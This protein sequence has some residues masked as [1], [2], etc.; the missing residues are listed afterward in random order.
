MSATVIPFARKETAPASDNLHPWASGSAFCL[1]CKH[2]WTA[3]AQTGEQEIECPCCLRWTG[4]WRF[5]FQPTDGQL[6]RVC[7]CSNKLFYL[8]PEGHLCGSCGTYQSY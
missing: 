1:A 6:V 5:E 2:E 8:T 3:V 7:N 4:H